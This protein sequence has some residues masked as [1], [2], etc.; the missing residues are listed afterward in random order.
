MRR[1]GLEF[2]FVRP[3]FIC[4][5]V[6]ALILGPTLGFLAGPVSADEWVQT[7]EDDFLGGTLHSLVV[8]PEGSLHLDR[9]GTALTRSGVV[10]PNGPAGSY[11]Y[12]W[13]RDPTVILDNG[14]YRMW[15]RGSDGARWRILYA[16]SADGISWTKQGVAL[17]TFSTIGAPFVMKENST[18]H[19]WFQTGPQDGGVIYHATSVDALVWSVDGVALYPGTSGPW[20]SLTVGT[21]WVVRTPSRLLLYYLGSDGATEAIGLAG[22]NNYTGFSALSSLPVVDVGPYGGWDGAKVRFP[23]VVPGNPWTMYYAGL[24]GGVWREGRA[25]SN[26]GLVWTKETRNPVLSGGPYPSWDYVGIVGGTPLQDPSG[27]RFYYTGTDASNNQIGLAV[28]GPAYSTYGAY[29]SRVFDSGRFRTTWR[30]ISTDGSFPDGTGVAAALRS[31]DVSSPDATWSSWRV[32]DPTSGT[33]IVPR[34]R[35]VQFLLAFITLDATETP[36]ITAVTVDYQPNQAPSAV[37]LSPNTDARADEIPVLIWSVSDA[38]NDPQTA[39]EVQLSRDASFLTIASTSGVVTSSESHWQ[40]PSLDPGVWHWRV[41]IFDGEAWG[42]WT[43]GKFNLS[44]FGSSSFVFQVTL[45]LVTSVGLGSAGAAALI[46]IVSRK[47][48]PEGSHAA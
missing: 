35:Y 17:D 38:E 25:D 30:T 10:I 36:I 11:D 42:P 12:Q 23:A 6:A 26:D 21:P 28:T 41:R 16:T 33:V 37:G 3:R 32:A 18:Y 48:R 29:E 27:L 14:T 9:N 2:R 34:S 13:A 43:S 46:W 4:V 7:S 1:V 19:M 40:P 31:G 15:Y 24:D 20:D 8:T 47:S 5:G 45:L 22:S 44:L 39:F